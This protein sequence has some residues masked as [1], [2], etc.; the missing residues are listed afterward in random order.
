MWENRF[1]SFLTSLVNATIVMWYLSSKIEITK[2]VF[3]GPFTTFRKRQTGFFPSIGN[4]LPWNLFLLADTTSARWGKATA[5]KS[6]E[7]M[8]LLPVLAKACLLLGCSVLASL[9]TLVGAG[10]M[11]RMG[12]AAASKE[13]LGLGLLFTSC[14]LCVAAVASVLKN[15][16]Y[17]WKN[18]PSI[19]PQVQL[20][21]F[22]WIV[23]C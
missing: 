15:K 2:Q 7:R 18:I 22:P 20:S 13:G 16:S 1:C 14:P 23:L 8:R 5:P 4:H 3:H 17:K 11:A 12:L 10:R 9:P 19:S 21:S 6:T